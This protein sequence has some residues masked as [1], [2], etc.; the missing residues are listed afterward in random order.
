MFA[1]NGNEQDTPSSESGDQSVREV[2]SQ[3]T[4]VLVSVLGLSV[5]HARAHRR[6]QANLLL[7]EDAQLVVRSARQDRVIKKHE[8][9]RQPE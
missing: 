2:L 6:N 4:E 5:E 7:E 3:D 8:K 1:L 9:K